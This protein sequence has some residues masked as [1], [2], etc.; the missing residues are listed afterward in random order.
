MTIAPRV[1]SLLPAATEM[2]AAV[3]MTE[4]LV[5]RSHECDYPAEVT[6]LPIATSSRVGR[7][8]SSGDIDKE[9]RRLVAEA[10]SLYEV[11]VD[12]LAELKPDVVVTQAL[13]DVC[14]VSLDEVNA[15]LKEVAQ[16]DCHVVSLE[17]MRLEHVFDNLQ[18]VGTALG[19][20]KEGASAV[21][22]LRDRLGAL[23]QRT[24]DLAP[25]RVLTLEWIEPPMVGGTWMGDLIE[26]AGGEALVTKPGDHAP[27]LTRDELYALDPEVIL[28]KPCG[29]EI[30]RTAAEAGS[31]R[32]ILKPFAA[33]PTFVADG[34]A[35]FNRPGP[36]LVESAEILAACMH[37]EACADL[38]AQHKAAFLPLA[39][40]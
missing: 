17:P 39:S 28:I 7:P 3:G 15:A 18:S 22:A 2:V 14:A 24:K 34:N 36:R 26:I 11:R 32:E 35:Y 31:L 5:G 23:Q 25:K 19:R 12:V 9:V 8:G 29:F 4:A 40:L 27:T 1:L 21:Q 20:E 10:T 33:I 6:H 16:T 38:A 37:P 30:E 13:C